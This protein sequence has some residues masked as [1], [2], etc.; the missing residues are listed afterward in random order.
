MKNGGK[1]RGAGRKPGVPNKATIARQER[2][3]A[4]GQTPLDYMLE[5]M[6]DP[7]A[8]KSRRDG[9][10][11]MAAPYVHP[12]VRT[13]QHTGQNGGPINLNLTGLSDEQL[14][15]LEPV[16][17]LLASLAGAS[18]GAAE[19]GQGGEGTPTS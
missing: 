16:L 3:A 15:T 19:P 9:M 13:V 2:V 1:R 10:A 12:Q 8:S 14:A 6:R 7:R 4:T 18:G 5:V 17:T 11:K